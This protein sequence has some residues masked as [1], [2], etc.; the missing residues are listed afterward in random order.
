MGFCVWSKLIFVLSNDI[1]LH[2]NKRK[3]KMKGNCIN[4]FYLALLSICIGTTSCSSD[5]DVA[6]DPILGTWVGTS[7]QED[8]GVLEL[9]ITFT[10]SANQGITASF[11]SELNDLSQCDNT[12]F[13]CE[14]GSCSGVWNLVS[15][16]GS[17]YEFKETLTGGDCVG[18]AD[19]SLTL[20]G[21][22]RLSGSTS[23]DIDPGDIVEIETNP[24]ELT[25]Q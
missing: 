17:N 21:E 20:I 25:R 15:Q 22:N 18:E 24:I 7:T 14:V 16:S 5:E 1:N 4:L 8:L 3:L 6:S 11:I 12:I 13:F 19:V 10:T 2:S 9:R 23:F